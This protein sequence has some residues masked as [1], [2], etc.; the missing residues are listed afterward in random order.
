M[1]GEGEAREM[2]WG[3]GRLEEGRYKEV[4]DNIHRAGQRWI[5]HPSTVCVGWRL[6]KGR[7]GSDSNLAGLK[8]IPK[9]RWIPYP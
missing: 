6:E 1:G 3:E 9:L 7:Q 5:P 2:R 4:P 8:W